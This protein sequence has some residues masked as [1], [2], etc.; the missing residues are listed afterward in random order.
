MP[1]TQGEHAVSFEGKHV[2]FVDLDIIYAYVGAC[3]NGPLPKTS[4]FGSPLP[5]PGALVAPP[6]VRV[7]HGVTQRRGE[8]DVYVEV[9]PAATFICTFSF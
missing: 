5:M 7:R 1:G 9:V 6:I 2:A 8:A 3:Y 4:P